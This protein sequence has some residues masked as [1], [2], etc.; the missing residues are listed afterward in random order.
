MIRIADYLDANNLSAFVNSLWGLPEWDLAVRNITITYFHQA[1]TLF[2]ILSIPEAENLYE[3]LCQ[4]DS[5]N[6]VH[7]VHVCLWLSDSYDTDRMMALNEA[8]F[9][10]IQTGKV[11]CP[12]CRDEKYTTTYPDEDNGLK[13]PVQIPCPICNGE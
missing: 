5:F 7:S 10:L 8:A 6:V 3:H 2:C 11:L 1:S 9:D 12:V 13:K 4:S